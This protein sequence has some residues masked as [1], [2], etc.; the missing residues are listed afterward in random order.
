MV[1]RVAVPA[2]GPCASIQAADGI[3]EGV[4]TVGRRVPS[5]REQ[6]V[7][8]VRGV[9]LD[10]RQDVGQVVERVM[11]RDSHVATSEYRPARLLPESTSPTNR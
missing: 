4:P 2:R 7:D 6:L 3:A 5:A 10:A 9:V 1:R 8:R 11:P